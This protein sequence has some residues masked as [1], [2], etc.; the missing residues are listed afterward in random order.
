MTH[1]LGIRR[2][3][4]AP[5]KPW[6][7][8]GRPDYKA[9]ALM[10]PNEKRGIRQ[11]FA[12]SHLTNCNEYA[13]S[14]TMLFR[15]LQDPAPPCEADSDTPETA[16]A[17][18]AVGQGERHLKVL[19]ELTDIAMRLARSLGEMAQVRIEA[20]KQT[21]GE[22]KPGEDPLSAFNR[23]A[24]TIRR[25][26][27]LEDKLARDVAKARAG[28]TAQRAT[29]ISRKQA[30]HRTAMEDAVRHAM[31]DVYYAADPQG[32]DDEGPE[33]EAVEN[34]LDDVLEHLEDVDEFSDYLDR[35]IGET[36]AKLCAAIGLEP[37]SCLFDGE[38]WTIRRPTYEFDVAR[39]ALWRRW[40]NPDRGLKPGPG[41]AGAMAWNAASG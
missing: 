1:T 8:R 7:R 38:A 29:N 9:K 15:T 6:L 36:V 5:R 4:L 23:L 19:A 22:L 40:M 3:A 17:A 21:G 35:P 33:G 16:D 30:E 20:A 27:A 25:T 24:Q 26:V 39:Q 14:R 18:I 32:R 28:L 2:P 37:D 34:L 10:V 13:L 11:N 12:F 31:E 41:L